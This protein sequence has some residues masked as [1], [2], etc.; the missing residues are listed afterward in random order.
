MGLD[1]KIM[2]EEGGVMFGAGNL[3]GERERRM[4][5]DLFSTSSQTCNQGSGR[6]ENDGFV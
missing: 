2:F 3:L 6:L 1:T 4:G 5:V